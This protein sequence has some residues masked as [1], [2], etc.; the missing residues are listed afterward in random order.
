MP[1]VD[2][3]SLNRMLP[4]RV[5]PE[6]VTVKVTGSGA[7]PEVTEDAKVRVAVDPAAATRPAAP[8]AARQ[9]MAM[10]TGNEQ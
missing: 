5:A 4:V 10:A 2:E 9:S 1:S 8:A 6:V 7:I 3:P